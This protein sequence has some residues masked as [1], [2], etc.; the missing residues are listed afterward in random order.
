[1]KI[2]MKKNKKKIQIII[3]VNYIKFNLSV[4]I[5]IDNLM[6]KYVGDSYSITG[7]KIEMLIL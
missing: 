4:N 6:N 5:K 1:M 2:L 7:I 3:K